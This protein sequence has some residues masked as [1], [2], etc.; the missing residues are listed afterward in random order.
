[1]HR[2][3]L[4]SEQF[5]SIQGEGMT[6]GRP[7]NFLRL[8][9]CNLMCGGAGTEQDGKL[10]HGATWR[11]DTIEVWQVGFLKDFAKV[12]ADFEPCDRLIV[13]GGEPLLHDEALTEF[14][15]Y[16]R[17]KYY[18][19]F[20]RRPY[21]EVETNGT[22]IPSPGL[23]D[24][25][26]Q[27]NVSPKLRNSGVKDRIRT[28]TRALQFLSN[29]DNQMLVQFKFVVTSASDLGEVDDFGFNPDQ[30][31]LMPGA[32]AS[33]PLKDL[34]PQVAEWAKQRRYNFSNRLHIALWNK[35]T[36]V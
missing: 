10:H 31:W 1:M 22:F 4:V 17:E 9:K 6:T 27:W 29:P 33:D 2:N 35:K 30:V 23:L 19:E 3:L 26:D 28:N 7:A 5:F 36:G 34:A 13:T 16:W 14:L 12:V 32:D 8:A 18:N 25:V 24:Y 20:H 11:C 15:A 21:V